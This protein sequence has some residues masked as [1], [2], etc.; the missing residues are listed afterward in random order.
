M[1]LPTIL[2][3]TLIPLGASIREKIY[4][5]SYEMGNNAFYLSSVDEREELSPEESEKAEESEI[6]IEG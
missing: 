1:L 6:N 4:Y 5:K 3:Y 2:G